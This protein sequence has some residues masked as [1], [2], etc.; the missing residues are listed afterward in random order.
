MNEIEN[1][2]EVRYEILILKCL[3]NTYTSPKHSQE[4]KT[5]IKDH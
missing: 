3:Y 4:S 1:T 5:T 2:K